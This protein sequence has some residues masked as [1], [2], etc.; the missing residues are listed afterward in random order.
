MLL[1]AAVASVKS[2]S[3]NL[4]GG[5][6]V[7]A[8]QRAA[9]L[10]LALELA[11]RK[12]AAS[13]AATVALSAA[14]RRLPSQPCC[15]SS[16]DRGSLSMRESREL[17]RRLQPLERAR[18]AGQ[19][20][21][22]SSVSARAPHAQAGQQSPSLRS[23]RRVELA[24]HAAMGHRRPVR[25]ER[26]QRQKDD[27]ARI[28]GELRGGNR[29]ADLPHG[30]QQGAEGQANRHTVKPRARRAAY[31]QAD[32]CLTVKNQTPKIALLNP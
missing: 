14:L 13:N 24:Q 2:R 4:L 16:S 29:G 3:A 17:S 30:N 23:L 12:A 5:R 11:N 21:A 9:R 22:T 7:D 27:G 18:V 8:V 28:L 15:Q 32:P 6:D 26:L 19:H 20:A 10:G 25:A 31:A 1:P